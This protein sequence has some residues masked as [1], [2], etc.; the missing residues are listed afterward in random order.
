MANNNTNI[1]GWVRP[2]IATGSGLCSADCIFAKFLLLMSTTHDGR[3]VG[4]DDT[5]RPEDYERLDYPPSSPKMSY[6][7]PQFSPENTNLSNTWLFGIN[8]TH[9]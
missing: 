4:G 3:S 6:A 5:R 9:T 7:K 8:L 1:C 2:R